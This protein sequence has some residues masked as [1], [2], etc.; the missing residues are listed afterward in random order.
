MTYRENGIF[1]AT[2][3]SIVP[4]G[5]FYFPVANRNFAFYTIAQAGLEILNVNTDGDSDS[6][7]AFAFGFGPGIA[8]FVSDNVSIDTG[9]SFRRVGGNIDQSNINLNIGLQ[10]FLTR[11]EKE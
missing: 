6:E 2:S 8:L 5:R 11:K 10:V 3:V 9:I 1:S 7:A 4:V